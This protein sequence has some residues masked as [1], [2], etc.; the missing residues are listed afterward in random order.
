M[1]KR[2][3]V[4][5][6]IAK[7]LKNWLVELKAGGQTPVEVKI[8][9]GIFRGDLLSPLL[10]VI[11]MMTFNYA[12]KKCTGGYKFIKSQEKINHVMYMNDIKIVAKNEKEPEILIQ[13]IKI[14]S[15]SKGMELGMEKCVML[16]MKK[17]WTIEK[18]EGIE[19]PN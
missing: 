8:Q 5:N 6:F 17:K 15:Q 16:I 7:V 18:R 4:I 13:T 10:F 3:K 9:R 2:F 19:L 14:Y 1:F 12:L 11:A